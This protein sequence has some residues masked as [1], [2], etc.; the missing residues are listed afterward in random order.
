MDKATLS[1]VMMR[2]AM[3][4]WVDRDID[5]T[6]AS[7]RIY[8]TDAGELALEEGRARIRGVSLE[9]APR[10]QRGDDRPDISCR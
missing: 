10:A 2:L 6:G 9:Q 3:R 1:E 8:V 5:V 4:G 7:Y